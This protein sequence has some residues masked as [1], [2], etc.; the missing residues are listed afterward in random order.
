MATGRGASAA[1]DVDKGQPLIG[2]DDGPKSAALPMDP[3]NPFTH[4]RGAS[5]EEALDRAASGIKTI[6]DRDGGSALSGFGSAKGSNC[7]L[8]TSPSPRD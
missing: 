8:Y 3:A 5:W 4:F 2:R 1:A 6:R 7:T